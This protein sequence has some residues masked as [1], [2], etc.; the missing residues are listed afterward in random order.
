MGW[1]VGKRWQSQIICSAI[2]A[3]CSSGLQICLRSS[4]HEWLAL[5]RNRKVMA[6]KDRG[7]EQDAQIE[8]KTQLSVYRRAMTNMTYTKLPG[9][10]A[11]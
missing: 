5:M 2:A 9:K 10:M 4:S 3:G 1:V 11:R 6:V 8:G 7:N